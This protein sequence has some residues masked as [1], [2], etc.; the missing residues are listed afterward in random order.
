M[1]DAL[2]NYSTSGVERAGLPELGSNEKRCHLNTRPLPKRS[3]E[4]PAEPSESPSQE[5]SGQ[6]KVSNKGSCTLLSLFLTSSGSLDDLIL[7][8]TSANP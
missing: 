2:P 7:L 6:E 1:C 8:G 5:F 3:T 4:V